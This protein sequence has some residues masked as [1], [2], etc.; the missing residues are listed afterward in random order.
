VCCMGKSTEGD[1]MRCIFHRTMRIATKRVCACA[2][3]S[4]R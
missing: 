4:C 2:D 3:N 1:G